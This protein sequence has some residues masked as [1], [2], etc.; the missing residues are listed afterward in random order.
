[1]AAQTQTLNLSPSSRTSFDDVPIA[2]NVYQPRGRIVFNSTAT[3]TSK[4][5]GDTKR[6]E[7]NLQLPPNFAYTLDQF[8]FELSDSSSD[9]LDHYSNLGAAQLQFMDPGNATDAVI[10]LVTQGSVVAGTGGTRKIWV[11]CNSR[12]FGEVF[13]SRTQTGPR[14]YLYF[15]DTDGVNATGA[16]SLNYYASFLEY[17]IAQTT[18][19][20]VNAPAPVSIR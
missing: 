15:Y 19:V 9:G 8:F 3:V 17:D 13:Y 10:E 20:N 11:P 7:I 5:A 4:A 14:V 18:K 16:L 12:F 2:Q 1:M 6:L